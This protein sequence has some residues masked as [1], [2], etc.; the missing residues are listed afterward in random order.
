M[1]VGLSPL[2]RGT[3]GGVV[4]TDEDPLLQK[5]RRSFLKASIPFEKSDKYRN[6]ATF[7]LSRES[8]DL[9]SVRGGNLAAVVN[10]TTR[11]FTAS[12]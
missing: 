11:L 2:A 10:V 6:P 7:P 4:R 5:T 3:T 12:Y 9:N 1:K 8:R